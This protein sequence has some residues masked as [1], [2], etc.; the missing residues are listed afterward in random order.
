[1]SDAH[2]SSQLQ[3]PDVM[4]VCSLPVSEPERIM[5][6]VAARPSSSS[7]LNILFVFFVFF[8]VCDVLKWLFILS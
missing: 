1:M 5:G 2:L 4:S 3:T 6:V 8:F 7:S